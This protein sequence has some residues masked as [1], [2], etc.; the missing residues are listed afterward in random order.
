M[1][2]GIRISGVESG[3]LACLHRFV[4]KYE[5]P[6]LAQ[7]ERSVR[8]TFVV[9]ELDLENVWSQGFEDRADLP[10]VEAAFGKIFNEGYY[11]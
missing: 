3:R 10:S 9:G 1:R 2:S 11:V 7:G 8:T 6:A 5:K 4:V